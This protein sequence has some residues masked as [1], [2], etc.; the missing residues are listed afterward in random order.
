MSIQSE[1]DKITEAKTLV[2]KS[3]QQVN[4]DLTLD[5]IFANYPSYI[6]DCSVEQDE[7]IEDGLNTYSVNQVVQIT[8]PVGVT[9]LRDYAF[10]NFTSLKYVIISGPDFIEL[11]D[12][13]FKNTKIETVNGCVF[14]PH[15][16]ISDY[17][18]DT[19]WGQYQIRSIESLIPDSTKVNIVET[20]DRHYYL[21]DLNNLKIKELS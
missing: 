3:I 12:N 2:R 5:E 11:G 16:L 13:V 10:A 4:S 15:T 18:T 7:Y 9:K 19:K 1:L 17:Q 6:D 21:S 14:V 20:V 8:I